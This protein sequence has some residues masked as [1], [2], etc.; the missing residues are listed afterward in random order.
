VPALH[1]L[2][3]PTC[4]GTL[5]AG[6]DEARCAACGT[7]FPVVDGIVSF[8]GAAPAGVED[9]FLWDYCDDARITPLTIARWRLMTRLLDPVDVGRVVI[10]VGGGGE[11][12][13]ARQLDGRVDDYVVADT[14]P[15]QLARQWFPAGARGTAIRAAGERLPL[16]DGCADTVEMWGVLDHLVD[17][18]AAIAESARVLR[19]TGRLLI[20]MG[21]DGSWYR[22]LAGQL[23]PD[24]SDAH[25]RRLDVAAIG[26]LLEGRFVVQEVT[27]LAYVRLPARVERLATRLSPRGQ[28]RLVEI[29]DAALR[30][31]VGPH[32]GGMMF[33]VARPTQPARDRSAQTTATSA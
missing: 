3:C 20:G 1:P 32:S 2:M 13:P 18:V 8:L 6:P 22:R 24:D 12:W 28:E 11:H 29:S 21:N 27:T 14:S 16:H 5:A 26:R 4:G 9:D 30:R 33:I 19:P 23:A 31:L 10:A 15:R 7:S 25:L 17:P